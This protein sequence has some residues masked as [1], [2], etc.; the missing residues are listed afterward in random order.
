MELADK[1]TPYILRT[2]RRNLSAGMRQKMDSYDVA[3]TL[4]AS[5]LLRPNELLRFRTPDDFTA[6]LAEATRKKIA[7]KKRTLLAQKRNINRE[8]PFASAD[9]E[10]SRE[11]GNDQAYYSK[12]PSPSTVASF[13]ER[14]QS[15]LKGASER[16]R[17]IV[18]LRL[19]RHTF[20]EISSILSI[21]EQTARRAVERILE[22]FSQ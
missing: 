5:V 3:Q 18:E 22:Q 11:D 1:Y 20:D 7:E 13:R 9:A 19:N 14:W 15:T 6:Y 10:K 16:D 21:H 8:V 12:D 2:V 17:Q 4:W